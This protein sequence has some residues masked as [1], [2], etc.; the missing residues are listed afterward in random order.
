MIASETNLP[1]RAGSLN[2]GQRQE[3]TAAAMMGST[4]LINNLAV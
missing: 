1:F 4:R 3:R 2:V